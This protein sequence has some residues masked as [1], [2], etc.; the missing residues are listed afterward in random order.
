LVALFLVVSALGVRIV[1]LEE[2]P[3]IGLL[4]L[5]ILAVVGYGAPA[6]FLLGRTGRFPTPEDT[7]YV[8]STLMV[9]PETE[10]AGLTFSWRNQ[11][12]ADLFFEANNKAAEGQVV[13]VADKIDEGET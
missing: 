7:L 13:K 10:P 12:T 6:F 8:R 4:V 1:N 3:G 9:R 2:S 11:G 5:L